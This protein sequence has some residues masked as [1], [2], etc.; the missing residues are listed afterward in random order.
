MTLRGPRGQARCRA[1][2]SA[3]RLAGEMPAAAGARVQQR[4]C[5]LRADLTSLDQDTAPVE[6]PLHLQVRARR[7]AERQL[8][9]S[10]RGS[11]LRSR[12]PTRRIRTS[13]SALPSNAASTGRLHVPAI[14]SSAM[15]SGLG[16][17]HGDGVADG[18][19]HFACRPSREE[20]KCC[21]EFCWVWCP[22]SLRAWR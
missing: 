3:G 15:L 6:E 21:G 1:S 5:K 22:R 12:S 13:F 4:I 17:S 20:Q 9:S 8:A 11:A 18:L 2:Q 19:R 16:V 10:S 14:S 7:L